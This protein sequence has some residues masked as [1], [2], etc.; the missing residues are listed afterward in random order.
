[1]SNTTPFY[2]SR[3][4][5]VNSCALVSLIFPAA[6]DWLA[7]NPEPA[8]SVLAAVNVLLR[9]VSAGKYEITD[10]S[11]NPPAPKPPSPPLIPVCLI[12]GV[13]LA[14]GSLSA[15]GSAV[16]YDHEA[17]LSLSK[18]GIIVTIHRGK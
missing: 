5:W 14:C 8:L 6:R 3:T 2:L 1:M 4:F 15:C 10:D 16:A 7:S 18:E 13:A 17:G 9:F 12:L 11:S